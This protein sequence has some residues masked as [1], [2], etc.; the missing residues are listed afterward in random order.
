MESKRRELVLQWLNVWPPHLAI[1]DEKVI[2][3]LERHK[4]NQPQRRDEISS[5]V[6]VQES[7]K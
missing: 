3:L 5:T 2:E 6:T 7:I 1:N 4:V